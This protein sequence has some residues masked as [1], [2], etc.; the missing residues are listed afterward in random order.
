MHTI[1]Q[2]AAETLA[3]KRLYIG[4]SKFKLFTD[5]NLEDMV[6]LHLPYMVQCRE[7]DRANLRTLVAL[8]QKTRVLHLDRLRVTLPVLK[9]ICTSPGAFP[10]LTGLQLEFNEKYIDNFMAIPDAILA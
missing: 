9:V 4:N 3:I 10:N 1:E 7:S 6:G 2:F 8:L 5:A